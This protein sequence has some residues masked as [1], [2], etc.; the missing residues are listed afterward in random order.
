LGGEK[1]LD[2]STNYID[3]IRD[4]TK[5]ALWS[6]NN[7]INCIPDSYWDKLYSEM[8]L[9][10][11][12]YHT[13]HSLDMWYINPKRY[14]EPKFHVKNLNNLDEVTYKLLPRREL[15]EY[16]KS[17]E[18][19]IDIYFSYLTEDMLLEKPED[20]EYTRFTLIL[21]QHRHLHT[22]MGMLMGFI[23]AGEGLWPKV[24]GL[25]DD[26]PEGEYNKYF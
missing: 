5:R 4:Q 7:I 21:A 1:T 8:P 17:I 22:H 12:V 20:C 15:K 19:K 3:I 23:I 25:E 11:H 13:L 9:W 10:K 24:I 18:K 14:E 16:Y 6:I 2:I 26:F